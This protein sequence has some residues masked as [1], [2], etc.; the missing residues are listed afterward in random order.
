MAK[1]TQIDARPLP[2]EV[3]LK[4]KDLLLKEIEIL[5][6]EKIIL[7]GNQV[8]SIVLNQKI[9]VTLARKHKFNLFINSKKYDAYA[10]F[11]P[12]GNGFFNKEKSIEDLKYIMSV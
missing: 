2:N 12:V 8:S 6:P 1:C 11:Y 10:V 4:Y 3:F 7:F 9:S 5:N